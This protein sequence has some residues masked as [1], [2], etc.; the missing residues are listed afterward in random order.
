VHPPELDV[1]LFL[2]RGQLAE[3]GR[4]H[5]GDGARAERGRPAPRVDLEERNDGAH[6]KHENVANPEPYEARK[7]Q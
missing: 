7:R 4:G 3:N 2:A 1:V 5:G 6:I